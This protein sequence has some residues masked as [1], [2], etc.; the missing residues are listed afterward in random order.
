M[1]KAE[2]FSVVFRYVTP[3]LLSFATWTLNDIKYSLKETNERLSD[4]EIKYDRRFEESNSKHMDMV[5]RIKANEIRNEA[6]GEYFKKES[7]MI[8]Y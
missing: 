8:K 3:L 7:K 1:Q 6:F 2:S 5:Q 4:M